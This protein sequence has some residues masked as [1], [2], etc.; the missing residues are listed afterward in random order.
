MFVINV[1]CGDDVVCDL[2]NG[3]Y[4]E[5]EETGG[6]LVGSYAICPACAPRFK[7]DIDERALPGETFRDF[8]LRI[9]RG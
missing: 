4:T 6:I 8:V 7:E 3:G 2:C 5:S 9:R 1:E